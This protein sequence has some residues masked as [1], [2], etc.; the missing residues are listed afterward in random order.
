MGTAG[1]GRSGDGNR[2]ASVGL[3]QAFW[4]NKDP[5]FQI[6]A[7]CLRE[8]AGGATFGKGFKEDFGAF[9]PGADSVELG[10]DPADEI[11]MKR[12][13]V[14]QDHRANGFRS[15]LGDSDKPLAN[16]CLGRESPDYFIC[17]W[18]NEC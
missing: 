13:G 12:P 8:G 1:L 18:G 9:W 16:D 5:N 7:N 14:R 6:T 15:G 4:P 10:D 3:Q 17:E 2:I 11:R